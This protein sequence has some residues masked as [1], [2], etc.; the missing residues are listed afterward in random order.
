MAPKVIVKNFN[1]FKGL[2][3]RSSDLTRAPDYAITYQNAVVTRDSSITNRV[4]SKLFTN[5]SA[6]YLGL[7]RYAYSDENGMVK[8]ELLS[9]SNSLNK[10]DE[11]SL[12]VTYSGANTLCYIEVL[13]DANANLQFKI[14]EG[15][16]V[17]QVSLGTGYESLYFG[18]N[19]LL[20]WINGIAGFAATSTG[21]VLPGIIRAAQVVPVSIYLD[22][23][24]GAKS[25][26]I[27]L[28]KHTM[29]PAPVSGSTAFQTYF[30]AAGTDG[31][32]HASTANV[33]NC[34]FIATGK[35]YLHVYDGQNVYRAGVPESP[36]PSPVVGA[37]G[38]LTGTYKYIATYIY[39]DNRLNRTEG[40]ESV[41]SEFLTGGIVTPAA[42]RITVTLTNIL[43][44]TGFNTNCAIV[45]GNQV[46]VTTINTTASNTMQV[47]DT[48][49]FLDRSSGL[50][51]TREVTGV[52]AGTITIAGAVVNVNNNDVISNNLRIGIYRVVDGGEDY[53][54]VDEVPNNSFSSTQTYSDNKIDTALGLQYLF[55]I[56]GYEHDVLTAKPK[57]L[58]VHQNQLIA[59]GDPTL[60]DTG[61]I[62]L[63]GDPFS[64]PA[65]AGTFDIISTKAG[66]ISGLASD[67]T[68]LV[69]GKED[70][71]FI[72]SGD[73]SE[74]GQYRF[75]RTN[76]T[77]GFA[78]HNAIQQIGEGIIFLSKQGFYRLRGNRI[79]EIGEPLNKVFFE[80]AYSDS[81]TM[82]LK[83][84][85]ACYI[86]SS[87]KFFCYVPCE[88]GSGA[89]QFANSNSRLFVYDSYFNGW[90]EWTGLNCGGGLTDYQNSV[91]WQSKRDDVSTQT[92][93][94]VST[95]LNTG[96]LYDYADH[97]IAI[98]WK[99]HP[100]WEDGGEPS[101]FKK[102]T[103]L[104]LY[105]LV[106][107]V[108]QP[109]F[110]MTVKT[111]IDYN[112]GNTHSDFQATFGSSSSLGYG[113]GAWG[114]SAWGTPATVYRVY[115]LRN[116]K[117]KTIRFMFENNNQ[118]EKV[119][120][121]GWEYEMVGAFRKEL[122]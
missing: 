33:A 8:E 67:Q 29:V 122:K 48:A 6:N 40:T 78:C 12:T 7:Y 80:K 59:A 106:R 52:T 27:S 109:S 68:V 86:N 32:E 117:V 11:G 87:E 51:V 53:F 62:S 95:H 116:T 111:E 72:G 79:D 71:L 73:F 43:A 63:P 120:L 45:N 101:V 17:N 82:Q 119:A 93:G 28:Y 94:N 97:G 92:R 26:V 47:G 37:A 65:V 1:S 113:Y 81:Q 3:K 46:G 76:N 57:Y 36:I 30:D 118:H 114:T 77:I 112:Y 60:P 121:S 61:F 35:E 42:Q 90:G 66:G 74:P 91:W 115:K 18:L 64:F 103:R 31:F 102:F 58:T 15:A 44:G 84:S 70:E 20:T 23:A 50:Y 85:W 14:V 75:E 41:S 39:I 105:N 100:Q 21:F 19:D 13:F 10:V 104:K 24:S 88:S 56:D 69:V 96:T 83:R 107:D 108:L 34:M 89:T 2:D 99:F 38:A 98:D 4:G 110:D 55:P 25:Q 49:Y 22:L 54:L 9:L 16:T 5:N